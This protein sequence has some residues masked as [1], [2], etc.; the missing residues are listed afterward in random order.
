MKGIQA[1]TNYLVAV[2]PPTAALAAGVR[3]LIML[4]LNAFLLTL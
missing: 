1:L 3:L 2:K 4:L